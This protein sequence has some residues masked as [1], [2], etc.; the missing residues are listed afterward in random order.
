[1]TR[2][3]TGSQPPCLAIG[4]HASRKKKWDLPHTQ[5]TVYGWT[6]WSTI[7]CNQSIVLHDALKRKVRTVQLGNTPASELFLVLEELNRQLQCMDELVLRETPQQ[8]DVWKRK[9]GELREESASLQQQGTAADYNRRRHQNSRYNSE[10]DELNLRR[11]KKRPG[12]ENEM[13]NL[14]DE[15]SSLDQ[16]HFM[17]SGL[18]SQGEASLTGLVE[19]RQRLHGV[20][21]V[22]ANIGSTLGLTQSTMKIIERRDITDAYLVAAGMVVTCLVIYFVWL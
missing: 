15:G 2:T 10:R 11:R 4:L 8:R 7:D 1:M 14:A 17:V 22:I 18:I 21:R 20:T 16:S 9:I 6:S 5:R 19:Q 13:Q 3:F 12:E